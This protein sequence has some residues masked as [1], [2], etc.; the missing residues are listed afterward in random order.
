MVSIR[1]RGGRDVGQWAAKKI[2]DVQRAAREAMDDTVELGK[3]TMQYNISTRGTAKSGKRGRIET[4][5]MLQSV[6]ADVAASPLKVVGRFGWLDREPAH[7]E[8]QEMGTQYIEPMLALTDA[9]E[10]AEV[11]FTSRF[12][13]I[14]KDI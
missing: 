4:G 13:S 7:A 14:A 10:D 2:F 12:D 8:F 6:D 5:D 11:E 1:S 9:Q 3:N